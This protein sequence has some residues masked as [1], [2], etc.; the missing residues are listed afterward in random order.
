MTVKT[1]KLESVL[2]EKSVSIIKDSGIKRPK[3][4]FNFLDDLIV[5]DF[6]DEDDSEDERL[7]DKDSQKKSEDSTFKDYRKST[8]KSLHEFWQSSFH[9]PSGGLESYRDLLRDLQYMSRISD[10][11][12]ANFKLVM[13]LAFANISK[14][15]K[16][17]SFIRRY[18]RADRTLEIQK[19]L[20][21]GVDCDAYNE[22]I[23]TTD[24]KGDRR[25]TS[26]R[27]L[28]MN[29][30]N[31]AFMSSHM[32]SNFR[33]GRQTPHPERYF[34][35]AH[36]SHWDD[37]N[38]LSRLE[39]TYGWIEMFYHRLEEYRPAIHSFH[40]ELSS[41]SFGPEVVR[42][43]TDSSFYDFFKEKRA[44]L[45]PSAQV[46][47]PGNESFCRYAIVAND[48][49]PETLKELWGKVLDIFEKYQREYPATPESSERIHLGLRIKSE[50]DRELT[51]I[52]KTFES[53]ASKIIEE[54]LF[55]MQS[56]RNQKQL[57]YGQSPYNMPALEGE[58]MEGEIMEGD[59]R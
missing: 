38:M 59:T 7:K 45:V 11:A 19:I 39:D 42:C 9:A 14:E 24:A 36:A 20:I 27:D 8:L 4:F 15:G 16:L 29:M 32:I 44:I 21:R 48:D 51:E 13:S 56:T 17:D 37:V 1:A 41:I 54:I 55:G 22:A 58:S 35:S 28:V 18:T 2:K 34:F 23:E 40:Q 53:K 5:E 26:F 6:S 3:Q 57:P 47:A 52:L 12:D 30:E 43:I 31:I 49:N 25:V 10:I 33:F 46:I 50:K